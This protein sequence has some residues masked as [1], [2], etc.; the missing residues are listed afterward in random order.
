MEALWGT[1]AGI[2]GLYGHLETPSDEPKLTR[3]R[4]G[5]LSTYDG[6][7]SRSRRGGLG[8]DCD[9]KWQAV[10]VGDAEAI[11]DGGLAVD[12]CG[13]I[14]GRYGTRVARGSVVQR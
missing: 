11:G 7:D 13:E 10:E 1:S 8:R 14:R 5:L 6:P 3:S 2:G 12:F 4:R 9:R